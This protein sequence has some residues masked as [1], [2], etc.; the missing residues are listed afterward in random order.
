MGMCCEKKTLIGCMEY[1]VVGSRPRG[2]PKRTWK[3]VV[4][5]DCQARK[6]N[7]EDA[8]DRGRC[9]K[10]INIGW[11]VFLLVLV[12][13]GSSGQSAVKRLLLLFC[14]SQLN[15]ILLTEWLPVTPTHAFHGWP[16]VIKAQVHV[17]THYTHRLTACNV[18]NTRTSSQSNLT[19]GHI[20]IAHRWL[21]CIRQPRH[22]SQQQMHLSPAGD[23]APTAQ[24]ADE[25]ICLFAQGDL[26][27]PLSNKWFLGTIGVQN[28][29]DV[30]N[31]TAVF[32]S[33]LW[34][35]DR[36]TTVLAL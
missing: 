12:H 3:E 19:K 22:S 34:R 25:R 33:W 23:N 10:L 6:L 27:P 16:R 14:C 30:S 20:V 35:T 9:K 4:Q 11:W 2:R 8:M 13:P 28:P 36:R 32:G 31:G 15:C 7:K 17:R 5:K 21:T 18:K 1:E 24:A 26:D 29:N